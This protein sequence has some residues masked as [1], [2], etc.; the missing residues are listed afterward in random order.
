MIYML[1]PG[2]SR[3]G[4]TMPG[5]SGTTAAANPAVAVVL[6]LFMLG[7]IMWTADGLTT[8]SQAGTGSAVMAPRAA[9]FSKIAMSLAMGYM[10]FMMV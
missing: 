4:V 6:A 8:R 3:P 2:G 5:M 9:A 10:L 1:V 7:Y